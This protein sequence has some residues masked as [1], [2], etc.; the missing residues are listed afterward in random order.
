MAGW[1]PFLPPNPV[2]SILLPPALPFLP[3]LK[4][5][6]TARWIRKLASRFIQDDF[7]RLDVDVTAW[8]TYRLDWLPDQVRFFVDGIPV[9]TSTLSPKPPARVGHLD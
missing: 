5:K 6:S 1:H 3:F 9:F 8:H 2:P 7:V 4:I